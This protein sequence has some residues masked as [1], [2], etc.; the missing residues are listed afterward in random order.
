M[1]EQIVAADIYYE[2]DAAGVSYRTIDS[3]G[4]LAHIDGR[5]GDNGRCVVLYADEYYWDKI[6]LLVTSLAADADFEG[7]LYAFFPSEE[8]A[9]ALDVSLF[10]SH[11]VAA[12]V[13]PTENFSLKQGEVL[14]CPGKMYSSRDVLNVKITPEM[15]GG[16]TI[17]DNNVVAALSELA[18]RMDGFGG[19]DCK[20]QIN[21]AE[22][23]AE[24]Y[25]VP[26]CASLRATIYCLKEGVRE[27]VRSMVLG[28]V[29]ELQYKYDVAVD[30]AISPCEPCVENDLQLTYEAMLVAREEGYEVHDGD[31]EF[32]SHAFGYVAE[33][34]PSLMY[35]CGVGEHSD[36]R[37]LTSTIVRNILNN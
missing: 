27:S 3:R 16:A 19:E 2:L 22:A 29:A 1:C 9:G 6:L 37:E 25:P 11:D 23:K 7:R 30:A 13:M 33:E 17:A 28:A 10:D 36:G 26:H 20:V 24:L 34:Y 31:A 14:F 32:S 8:F 35:Y 5:R 12:A 15:V 21:N 18:L 4:V